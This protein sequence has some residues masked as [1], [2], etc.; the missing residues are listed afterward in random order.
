M[1]ILT[2]VA[3]ALLASVA[4]AQVEPPTPAHPEEDPIE[5]T[6]KATFESLDRNKDERVS[7]AEA[8]ADD[9][10]SSE[11]AAL[12]ADAD[13]YI[14]KSEYMRARQPSLPTPDPAPP[15]PDPVSPDPAA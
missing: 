3:A 11:F 12:D 9:G 4:V 1:K 2:T 5:S 14:N 13:G 7:K 15:V 8:A 6:A 10:L